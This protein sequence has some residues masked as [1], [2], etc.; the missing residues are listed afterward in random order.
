MNGLGLGGMMAQAFRL[1]T[2]QLQSDLLTKP[3]EKR[4]TNRVVGNLKRSK[5]LVDHF[6]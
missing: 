6:P 4:P 3:L 1:E 5:P 2:D